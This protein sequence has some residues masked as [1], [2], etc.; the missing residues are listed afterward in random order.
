LYGNFANC[1]L[2][3]I[4][5]PMRTLE[6]LL[7]VTLIPALITLLPLPNRPLRP[8]LFPIAAILI[9]LLHLLWEGYRWQMWPAYL[10]VILVALLTVKQRLRPSTPTTSRRGRVALILAGVAA[11]LWLAAATALPVL[12]PVPKMPTP[13]GSY[14]IGTTTHYFQDSSR[15]EIYTD[16]PA[17]KRELMVQLWYPAAAPDNTEPA[18]YIGQLDIAGPAIATRLDL[19]SFLLDHLNLVE[20][21]AY[22]EAQPAADN[23]RFPVLIFSHGLRGFRAQ[24]SV[25]MEELASQGY[26]VASIDHTYGNIFTVFP[27]GRVLFYS[28]TVLPEGEPTAETGRRLVS[29]WADD[30]LF[31][32][33]QLAAMNED[34]AS[35]LSGR[36][37]LQH[38]AF[39]GHSTGGG[40][41]VEACGRAPRCTAGVAL[42]SWLEPVSDEVA[43]S[44]DRPFLFIN[45]PDWLGPANKER[46]LE[47]YNDMSA[48]GY[49]ATIDGTAHYDFSDLPLLSPL[50]QQMGLSGSLNGDR[51]VHIVNTYTLAFLNNQLKGQPS[52]LLSGNSADYPELHLTTHTP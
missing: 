26:L 44:L 22:P 50:T 10:L 4:K 12:L 2:R 17:D 24:N 3:T 18:P 52:P 36:L 35:P 21:H 19:P 16:D 6:I 37:D 41:A 34:T 51:A 40:T 46:A 25:L 45:T 7:L 1:L 47:I 11:F 13:A 38:I 48:E 20:T 28:D 42:D 49:L 30:A 27:D 33:D 14:P 5:T 29:V 43:A 32:L 39:L 23:T 9:T 31:V 8:S 15:D